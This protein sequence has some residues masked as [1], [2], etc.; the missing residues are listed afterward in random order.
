MTV[1]VASPSEAGNCS[2]QIGNSNDP[3]IR[4]FQRIMTRMPRGYPIINGLRSSG[5]STLT[6]LVEAL[7]ERGI[8]T[9]QGRRCTQ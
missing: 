8:Q 1:L 4:E 5:I 3:S 2:A 7:N 6:G 9:P